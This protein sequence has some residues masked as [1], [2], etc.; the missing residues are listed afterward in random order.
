MPIRGLD[1]VAD[2]KVQARI[3]QE[4]ESRTTEMQEGENDVDIPTP[5][6]TTPMGQ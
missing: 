1:G 2:S 6:T 5:D 4:L 3:T